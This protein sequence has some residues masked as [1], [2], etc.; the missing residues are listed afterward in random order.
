MLTSSLVT[1]Q[2]L[3]FITYSLP[4]AISASLVMVAGTV[5]TG[6]VF[7]TRSKFHVSATVVISLGFPIGSLVLSPLSEFMIATYG[8]RYLKLLHAGLIL[9]VAAGCYLILK[10]AENNTDQ[11]TVPYEEEFEAT[12]N[13]NEKNIRLAKFGSSFAWFFG[14]LCLSIGTNSI[15]TNLVRYFP[16]FFIIFHFLKFLLIRRMVIILG[17]L[18][19]VIRTSWLRLVLQ[20]LYSGYLLWHSVITFLVI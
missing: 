19:R 13:E 11:D 10:F 1:N 6:A 12:P 9:I 20:I 7:P 14:L 18:K 3:L 17:C 16:S 2:H 5:M 4:F 8:W 15:I